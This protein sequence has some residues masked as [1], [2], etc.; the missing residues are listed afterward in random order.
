MKLYMAGNCYVN[1]LEVFILGKNCHR[2]HSYAYQVE[3]GKPVKDLKVAV[4]MM[5][6]KEIDVN[7]YRFKR[8]PQ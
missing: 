1:A 5:D 4:D 7:S 8:K 6:G 3:N 2:L